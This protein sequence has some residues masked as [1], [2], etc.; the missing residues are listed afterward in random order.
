MLDAFDRALI[1][2][3]QGGL[4]LTPD[5]YGELARRLGRDRTDVLARFRALL[6]A[7]AIRRIGVIPNHYALG[8]LANGMSVW[9]IEDDA[10]AEL[11]PR[12][13]A[14]PFVSHCYRRPRHLPEWRYNV[15][16]MAHGRSREEVIAKVG[17]IAALIGPACRAHDILFSKRILKKTGLRL[18]RPA[19]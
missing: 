18:A 10:A 6:E 17:E 8:V 4:P 13:G 19:A 14:L 1:A 11:G 5:P 12:I 2:A 15:F 7:G 9:D 3:T 16:A